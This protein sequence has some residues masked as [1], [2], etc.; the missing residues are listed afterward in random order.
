M[1]TKKTAQTQ[2]TDGEGTAAQA[3]A[4]AQTAVA[5]SGH[6]DF[7]MVMVGRPQGAKLSGIPMIVNT[8]KT[9]VPYD[10]QTKVPYSVYDAM[11]NATEPYTEVF[12]D[13]VSGQ[14]KAIVKSRQRHNMTAVPCVDAPAE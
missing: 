1:S 7:M 10:V 3:P 4:T 6:P 9:D 13:P 14:K 2:G 11:K 5:P 8:I 12:V